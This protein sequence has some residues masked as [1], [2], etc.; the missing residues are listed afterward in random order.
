[1]RRKVLYIIPGLILVVFGAWYVGNK[2][3]SATGD[4]YFTLAPSSGT[5]AV[6]H[7]ITVSVSETSSG[8]DNTNAVQANLSWPASLTWQSTTLTGP[9]SLCGQNA[10]TATSVSIGCAATS[11]QSGTQ[12][13][14]TVSLTVASGG[15]NASVGMI[16]GSDIDNTSGTS[17]WNGSL[18]GATYTLQGSGGTPTPTP[19]PTHTPT[20]TPTPSSSKS[21]SGS[22]KSSSTP[23]PSASP[24]PSGSPSKSASPK[25][26][27]SAT[28]VPSSTSPQATGSISVTVSDVKGRVDGAVVTVS[29]QS[30]QTNTDGVANFAGVKPGSYQVTVTAPGDK[31]YT[32]SLTLGDGQNKLV[33]YKLAKA[34]GIGTLV[35]ALLVLVVVVGAAGIAVWYIKAYLPS[36]LPMANMGAPEPAVSNSPDDLQPVDHPV[37]SSNLILPN[38]PPAAGPEPG[39]G[40]DRP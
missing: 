1:M 27:V 28:P 13:I 30:V 26:S 39:P 12:A 16:S 18:P 29:G 34:T 15:S 31:A 35:V 5:Y 36:H 37:Q 20:P 4:A 2:S 14:A 10:H 19:T 17:V 32:A 6:G 38:Q 7:T 40:S 25:P 24:S 23:T 11:P 8:G 22:S 21:G 9:F 3:A 33:S